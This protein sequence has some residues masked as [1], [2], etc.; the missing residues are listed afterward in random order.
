MLFHH[1]DAIQW[2]INMFVLDTPDRILEED[3][4]WELTKEYIIIN[5]HCNYQVLLK[6]NLSPESVVGAEIS[7][8]CTPNAE[9]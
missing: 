8:V 2:H 9:A 6:V 5:D 4:I 1:N 7:P 3:H